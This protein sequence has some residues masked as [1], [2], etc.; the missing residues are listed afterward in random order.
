MFNCQYSIPQYFA[1]VLKQIVMRLSWLKSKELRYYLYFSLF[2]DYSDQPPKHISLGKYI[3]S[4]VPSL[5][6]FCEESTNLQNGMLTLKAL[7]SVMVLLQRYLK[8][9]YL[10]LTVYPL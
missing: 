5:K 7:S 3:A 10:C 4:N 9:D 6:C 1:I 8:K 2:L